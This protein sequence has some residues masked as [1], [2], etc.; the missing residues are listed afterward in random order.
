MAV[1]IGTIY[2]FQ[3]WGSVYARGLDIFIQ[4]AIIQNT[5]FQGN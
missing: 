3:D 2:G 4:Y 1:S 5:D